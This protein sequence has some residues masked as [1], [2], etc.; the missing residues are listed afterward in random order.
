MSS[1]CWPGLKRAG[2]R[3]GF[4][5]GLWGSPVSCPVLLPPG[6]P[7]CVVG[8]LRRCATP[9]PPGAALPED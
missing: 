1:G 4:I 8:H 2:A 5:L 9:G 7:A 3:P 6:D